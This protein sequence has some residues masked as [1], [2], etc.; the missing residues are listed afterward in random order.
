MYE[1]LNPGQGRAVLI[2]ERKILGMNNR[3]GRPWREEV[4]RSG[5]L[6]AVITLP[7]KI[8]KDVAI[9]FAIVI[10]RPAPIHDDVLFI[11]AEDPSS[12]AKADDVF[13]ADLAASIVDACKNRTAIDGFAQPVSRDDLKNMSYELRPSALVP[14]GKNPNRIIAGLLEQRRDIERELR[15]EGDAIRKTIERLGEE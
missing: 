9:G 14:S 13:N 6:D 3:L 8:F 2:M 5:Q 15:L 11:Y 10:L 1:R 4:V 7:P 12:T